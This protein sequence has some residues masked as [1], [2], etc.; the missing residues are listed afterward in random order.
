[1]PNKSPKDKRITKIVN[2]EVVEWKINVL[3]WEMDSQI[4][5]ELFALK[6]ELNEYINGKGKEIENKQTRERYAGN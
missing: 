1:M 4:L 2:Q 3:P 6:K 5:D